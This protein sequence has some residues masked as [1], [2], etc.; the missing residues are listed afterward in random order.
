MRKLIIEEAL[1]T[2]PALDE[3]SPEEI[4]AYEQEL[5]QTFCY[6]FNRPMV[7]VP[8]CQFCHEDK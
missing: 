8:R 5:D 7:E 3:L 1:P 4:A 6:C 2:D